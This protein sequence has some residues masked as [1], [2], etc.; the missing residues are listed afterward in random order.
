L[1]SGDLLLAAISGG[2]FVVAILALVVIVWLVR[3]AK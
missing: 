1:I 3:N 2:V